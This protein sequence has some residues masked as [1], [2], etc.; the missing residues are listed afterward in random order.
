[1][2]LILA[3]GSPRRRELLESLRLRFE[4]VTGAVDE[5]LRPEEPVEAYVERLAREKAEAVATSRPD[6][7][8]IAADT[9]VWLD[10]R[11]L[12][13]PA[14][15]DDAVRMLGAIAGREHVVYTGTALLHGGRGWRRTSVT[16]TRVRMVSLGRE[17]IEWYVATGEPM[18][19]AGAY[20]VQGIG[21]MYV[22][23]I[24]GNYTNVVGLPL[25]PLLRMMREA[26][27][28]PAHY[29]NE[30]VRVTGGL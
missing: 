22:E 13:K 9:V 17:E 19:K 3:S 26:G 15:R 8:I 5:R 24:E 10:G 20:A 30:R 14:D 29:R 21:S 2:S 23:S 1:M 28:D 7:W 25:A 4:V 18:D 16:A 12:G 6:A 27:I 11:I